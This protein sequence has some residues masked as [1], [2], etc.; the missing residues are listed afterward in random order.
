MGQIYGPGGQTLAASSRGRRWNWLFVGDRVARVVALVALVITAG[1]W[2]SLE[3]ANDIQRQLVLQQ[4]ALVSS[5]LTARLL[6]MTLKPGA[7]ST[8]VALVVRVVNAGLG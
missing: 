7:D 6:S 5:D 8:D 1:Q 2:L 3:Q 4:K